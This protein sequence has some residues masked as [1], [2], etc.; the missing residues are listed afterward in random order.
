MSA[1]D[2]LHAAFEPIRGLPGWSVRLGH[3]SFVTFEFGEPRVEVHEVRTGPLFVAGERIDVPKRQ[4][5]VHGEWHLWIYICEWSLS[6]RDRQIAHSESTDVEINRALGVLNGQS[7]TGVKA[8]T[9]DGCS[10][11]A[12]DLDCVLT[13]RPFDDSEQWMFFQPSGDV[14]TLQA[15]GRLVTNRGDEPRP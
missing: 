7:V 2:V 4:A 3:G 15:D 1:Q 5:Y 11:F 14:L 10:T 9:V 13:T 8:G 6:W 12:F